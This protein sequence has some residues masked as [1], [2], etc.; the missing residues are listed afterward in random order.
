M[1]DKIRTKLF[2]LERQKDIHI[3]N[4]RERGSRMLGASHAGSDWDVLF[5]FS[6]DAANYATIHGR[7]DSIHE[8]H[9]GENEEIDL[10]G[11]N[12]DKFGELVR[13]S[14]PNAIEYCREDAVEYISFPDDGVFDEL[15]ED[16][17]ESF[18]HMS[19]YHHYISMGKRNWKKY[20]DSGNDC[21]LGRQFY[22]ARPIAAAKYIRC[23][24]EMAPMDAMELADEMHD[25]E[26]ES[27]GTENLGATLAKLTRAK[28]EGRGHVE[29]EDLVGR[30]Y[31]AESEVSM[32]PTE[33][34]IDSP[35][36]E[37]IDDFIRTAIVR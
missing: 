20:I 26:P 8:P 28:Q 17:R 13:D 33:E 4:A 24:G 36:E 1:E 21:T 31:K 29:S 23:V 34:R 10:H 25:I 16:A 7:I 11:W 2:E 12:V 18:N 5:L 9:L 27:I 30:F 3:V 15:A 14:N 35:D 22:V 6:Q 19:L 32:E 37:L